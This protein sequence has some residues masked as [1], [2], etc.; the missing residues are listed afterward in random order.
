[1]RHDWIKQSSSRSIFSQKQAM[2]SLGLQVDAGCSLQQNGSAVPRLA[3][4][5]TNINDG[6]TED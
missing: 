3:R 2:D 1:M 6:T 4:G 5:M